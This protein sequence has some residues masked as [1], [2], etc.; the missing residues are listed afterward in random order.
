MQQSPFIRHR[1]KVMGYY[2]TAAWLRCVVL[3]MWSGSTEKVGLSQLGSIDDDHYRAF[4]EMT[5]HYRL[6]GENDPAFHALVEEVH[7]RQREEQ[8]AKER[9][10]RLEQWCRDAKACLRERGLRPGELDDRYGWFESLFDQGKTPEDA[11]RMA[12][13]GTPT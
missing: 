3:A 1:D 5:G 9:E 4:A 7:A 13:A 10:E 2:G 11:A 8:E 12:A 6:H